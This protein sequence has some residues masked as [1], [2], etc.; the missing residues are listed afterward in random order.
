MHICVHRYGRL[1]VHT[2][3]VLPLPQLASEMAVNG[4]GH[5]LNRLALA[6]TVAVA[7]NENLCCKVFFCNP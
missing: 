7:N 2:R 4:E 3:L 6:A 1:E 5:D